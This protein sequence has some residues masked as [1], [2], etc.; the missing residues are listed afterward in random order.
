VLHTDLSID[1]KYA[2]LNS[3]VKR[4][5]SLCETLW[6]VFLCALCGLFFSLGPL[7]FIFFNRK[8][9][10]GAAENAECLKI[11]FGYQMIILPLCPPRF[12]YFNRKV[13]RGAAENAECLKIVFEYPVIILPLCPP[14]FIYFNR[15]VRRGAAENA[16]CLKIVFGYPMI[17]L[18]LCPLRLKNGPSL[19]KSSLTIN[20]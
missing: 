20:H 4:C 2:C 18:P 3:S 8:V 13:R 7:R 9:R 10:K 11:V 14:R 5:A 15:K 12:I 16:E 19:T 17:I 1:R 6:F